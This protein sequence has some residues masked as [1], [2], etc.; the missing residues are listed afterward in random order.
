M[1]LWLPKRTSPVSSETTQ[2]FCFPHA[3]SGA[4]HYHRWQRLLA[5]DIQL[6]PVKLP[7]RDSRFNEDAIG[8]IDQLLDQLVPGILDSIREPFALFGHSM[9]GLIAYEL[10][11]RLQRENLTPI[12]LFVSA[13]RAPHLYKPKASGTRLYE[14]PDNEMIARLTN[15]FGKGRD[16]SAEEL[17]MMRF[18]VNTIRADLRLLGVYEHRPR[19]PLTA[20]I[21]AF[22]ASE[23]RVVPLE[24]VSAWRQHTSR[25]FKILTM[26]GHHFYLRQQE[27]SLVSLITSRI[28]AHKE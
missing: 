20:P 9:G 2:L 6:L 17:Q 1:S 16:T 27:K 12:I 21:T 23:D 11:D 26:P 18:M 7:G 15:D 8:E 14:L 5:E 4:A 25:E 22:A 28:A 13:S 10:A 19:P 24:A 3:G